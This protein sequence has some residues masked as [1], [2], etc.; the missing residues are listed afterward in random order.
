MKKE[1]NAGEGGE[2]VLSLDPYI[3]QSVR[4]SAKKGT[5]FYILF[6]LFLIAAL[7]LAFVGLIDFLGTGGMTYFYIAAGLFVLSLVFVF[8]RRPSNKKGMEKLERDYRTYYHN[9]AVAPSFPACVLAELGRSFIVFNPSSKTFSFHQDGAC[10]KT[11]DA[12]SIE[13]TEILDK[14]RSK[15]RMY[16]SVPDYVSLKIRLKT[17]EDLYLSLSNLYTTS[18]MLSP[19]PTKSGVKRMRKKNLQVLKKAS[20]FLDKYRG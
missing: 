13:S 17:G 14:P 2:S 16:R 9:Q 10:R 12:A 4:K 3:P 7:A 5:V 8:F 11:I 19:S 20:E 15:K 1:K 18:E 6:L